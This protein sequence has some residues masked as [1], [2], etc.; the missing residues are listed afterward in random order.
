MVKKSSVNLVSLQRDFKGRS[1]SGF[2][3][4]KQR[5]EL[6]Q[7]YFRKIG[8]QISGKWREVTIITAYL[9]ETVLDD[10]QVCITGKSTGK[11]LGNMTTGC[12]IKVYADS[13]ATTSLLASSENAQ[14]LLRKLTKAGVELYA[15]RLGALF[16]A[17][18]MIVSTSTGTWSS[19]GSLNFTSRGH[20]VNEELTV[21]EVNAFDA[22]GLS[23]GLAQQLIEYVD[24][25][26]KSGKCT[27][28]ESAAPA[29]QSPVDLRG[30]F[31]AGEL[32]Y[33]MSETA[34]FSFP[35]A[36]SEEVKQSSALRGTSISRF[37]KGV[38]PNAIDIRDVLG[39]AVVSEEQTKHRWK[40]KYCMPTCL[41]LWAPIA[42]NKV[43]ADA[44]A[45]ASGGRGRAIKALADALSDEHPT[46]AAAM[47]TEAIVDV[48]K[49][50]IAADASLEEFLPTLSAIESRANQWVGRTRSKLNDDDFR[51][52]FSN[53]AASTNMPDIWA[54]SPADQAEFERTFFESL[55]YEQDQ[56]ESGSN[57]RSDLQSIVFEMARVK[58]SDVDDDLLIRSFFQ[59]LE[60]ISSY[61]ES[62][63]SA[64][65][66]D[67]KI[68]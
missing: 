17:K 65:E 6:T 5:S 43:I 53:N 64:Y 49:A 15:V 39:I 31:L 52:R 18:G 27:L 12:S 50:I 44:T 68:I 58:D 45:A 48:W 51:R 14:K 4:S 55:R 13:A 60:D 61:I 25:L 28:I 46:N 19:V 35:M 40:K 22:G 34:L 42:W 8:A 63:K 57:R 30:F 56:K 36:F 38:A 7:A 23:R 1:V 21:T 10:L 62:E 26:Q 59:K 9:D 24:W 29:P 41:G 37:L 11:A 3:N 54:G 2:L 20:A 16:H 67:A 47:L 66:L 33:E 32:W